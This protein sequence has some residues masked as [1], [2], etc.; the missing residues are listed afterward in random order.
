MILYLVQLYLGQYICPAIGFSFS[1]CSLPRLKVINDYN[2]QTQI[3]S[4]L[5]AVTVI[6]REL[7]TILKLKKMPH[8]LQVNIINSSLILHIEV[9]F[10]FGWHHI[11]CSSVMSLYK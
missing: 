9:N 8:L 3:S 6:V 11:Y 7:R 4:N 5:I 1:N 2:K 10:E